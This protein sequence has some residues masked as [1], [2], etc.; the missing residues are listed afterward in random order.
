MTTR[1]HKEPFSVFE[2]L[3]SENLRLV[4][5]SFSNGYFLAISKKEDLIL[6]TMAVS[7]PFT[8]HL[9]QSRSK[10]E[11]LKGSNLLSHKDLTTTTVLGSRNEVMTKALAEKVVFATG[12]LVYLSAN[13]PENDQELFTEALRLVEQFLKSRQQSIF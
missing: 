5:I 8:T 12:K 10:Q 9:S 7:L 13:F 3:E 4:A 1:E 6:G 2:E 11:E